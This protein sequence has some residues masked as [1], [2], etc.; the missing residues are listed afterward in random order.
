MTFQQWRDKQ[1]VDGTDFLADD[2]EIY[3]AAQRDTWAEVFQIVSDHSQMASR[4]FIKKLEAARGE[5]GA[6]PTGDQ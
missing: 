6:G 5:A 3:K 2:E 1:S 4:E